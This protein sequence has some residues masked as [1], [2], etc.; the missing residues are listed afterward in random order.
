MSKIFIKAKTKQNSVDFLHVQKEF[1]SNLNDFIEEQA[2]PFL[3][4]HKLD[5][6]VVLSHYSFYLEK[7]KVYGI[8]KKAQ[9]ETKDFQNMTISYG[10]GEMFERKIEVFF[11][12]STIVFQLDKSKHSE[13]FIQHLLMN[14]NL[15]FYLD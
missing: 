3:Q 2:I 10:C 4:K 15:S 8:W 13:P 12:D 1:L 5:S 14:S 6:F 11:E 7:R 9:F